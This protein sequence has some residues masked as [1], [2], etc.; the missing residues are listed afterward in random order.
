LEYIGIR[1][2]YYNK[3]CTYDRSRF[4]RAIVPRANMVGHVTIQSDQDKRNARVRVIGLENFVKRSKIIVS[5]GKN[6]KMADNVSVQARDMFASMK[7]C[8]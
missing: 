7:I 5:P 4:R 3:V 1:F 6:V 2:K 8:C